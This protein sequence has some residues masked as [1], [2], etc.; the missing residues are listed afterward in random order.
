MTLIFHKIYFNKKPGNKLAFDDIVDEGIS[1]NAL[2]IGREGGGRGA[3]YIL[4]SVFWIGFRLPPPLQRAN[5]GQRRK[6]P[7]LA[8]SI[9][10]R[11][12]RHLADC[13]AVSFVFVCWHNK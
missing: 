13:P 12:S 9:F 4:G 2:Q 5:G 11:A 3:F 10:I 1:Q 8:G 7:A 6:K